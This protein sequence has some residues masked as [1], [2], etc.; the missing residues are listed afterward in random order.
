MSQQRSKARACKRRQQTGTSGA[1]P[2]STHEL[3]ALPLDA[4]A[5]HAVLG[6]LQEPE[7]DCGACEPTDLL[8]T[9]ARLEG[10]MDGPEWPAALALAFAQYGDDMIEH[11]WQRGW[12]PQ[13]VLSAFRRKLGDEAVRAG[14]VLMRGQ[15][16]S[17]PDTHLTD[18][19]LVQRADLAE[20][21]SFEGVV[22]ASKHL[23]RWDR[24]AL[25]AAVLEALDLVGGLPD[26]PKVQPLPGNAVLAH[27]FKGD[28]SSRV[29]EKIRALLAKA[30]STDSDAE[31]EAFTAKAQQLIARHSINEALL[32]QSGQGGREPDAARVLIE[33]PYEQAK[34]ELLAQIAH[35]NHCRSVHW[36]DGGFTTLIGD[37]DDLR[38]VE[39]LFNSLLVQAT[40]AMTRAGSRTDVTGR[41]RTRTFR[42]SFLASFAYRIG[43]RLRES[44][45]DTER[46]VTEETGTDLVPVMRQ[47]DERIEARTQNLFPRLKAARS[48]RIADYEG[49]IAGRAAADAA[50]LGAGE[51][52]TRG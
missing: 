18:R 27:G 23:G 25:W 1:R 28:E 4:R 43:E 29:Y 41:P 31:A 20:Q 21:A 24:I 39:L 49:H 30:E 34:A 33:R 22:E 12:M 19:W 48:M 37:R 52:I 11:I 5:R 45:A 44:A 14:V 47:R 51:S 16:A 7:C 10:T 35:A 38:S 13:E 6:A 26:I 3:N 50:R 42:Q 32:S 17:Y 15:L 2:V 9:A 8:D 46:E 40:A 36:S